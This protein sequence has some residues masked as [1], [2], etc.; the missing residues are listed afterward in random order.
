VLFG[1]GWKK[2]SLAVLIGILVVIPFSVAFVPKISISPE[3]R[4]IT[5]VATPAPVYVQPT[6]V[7]QVTVLSQEL[8]AD[9]V[10]RSVF[11]LVPIVVISSIGAAIATIHS[12]YFCHSFGG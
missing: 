7:Q 1:I 11:N 5:T 2:V 12:I 6:A 9:E 10:A 8:V 4:T 3:V